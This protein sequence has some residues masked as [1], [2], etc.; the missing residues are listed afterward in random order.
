MFFY[1]LLGVFVGGGIG[2]YFWFSSHREISRLDEEKQNLIQERHIVLK[3]MHTMVEAIGEGVD[4]QELF[5]RMVHAAVVTT[6][7]MS[8]C[9][10]ELKNQRLRGVALE[11]LFPPQRRLRDYARLREEGTRVRYLEEAMRSETYSLGEGL[12]GEVARSG[13]GVFIPNALNHPN[14]VQHED[15][16]LQVTSLIVVPIL[17]RAQV[18]GV[19]AIANPADGFSFT[20]TDFS[21]ANS[22]A[23]QAG[24]AIHN[25]DMMSIQIAQNRMEMDLNLASSIQSM[26]LPRRFPGN[27]YLDI[28]AE[29]RPA[30][31]V[32]GDLYDVFELDDH[33]VAV[34][35]ADVSGKGIPASLIMAI[36]QSNLRYLARQSQRPS[37]VLSALN[38]VMF[39]EIQRGMFVTVTY[40]IVDTQKNCILLA[41]GGHELPMHYHAKTRQAGNDTIIETPLPDRVQEMGSEGMALG[42]VDPHVFDHIITDIEIPFAAGDVLLLYTDGITESRNFHGLEFT[43]RRLREVLARNG[44][45]SAKTIN[46]KILKQL[47]QFGEGAEQGDDMTLVTI[48]RI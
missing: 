11:G 39:E 45:E 41:R 37:E 26:L 30:Q 4:R 6:S 15:P 46:D 25:L 20:E 29:Y 5:N 40:A 14:V 43:N 9:L 17:F 13:K 23:E 27:E 24:L 22:L 3:F 28:A 21:L 36:C 32:G 48:R 10:F 19:L 31:K 42:M 33:R 38:R 12:I 35:I 47:A 2:W 18:I 1:L 7:G 8:A 16:V 44:R 34:A